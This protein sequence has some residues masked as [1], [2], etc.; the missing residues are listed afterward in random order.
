MKQIL[1]TITVAVTLVASSASAFDPAH[2]KTL[3]D[4]GDCINCDLSG[5][6]LEDAKLMGADLKGAKLMGA[7]LKVAKLS[8]A[9][10]EGADLEGADLKDANLT[11]AELSGANLT[12]ANLNYAIMEG[13]IFCNTTMPDGSVIYS[14]C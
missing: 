10:L 12:G 8:G 11:E 3:K 4:T 7:D 2:L 9:N 13:V 5:A 14:G 1:A 6:N